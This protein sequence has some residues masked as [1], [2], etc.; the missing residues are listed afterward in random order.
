VKNGL[1]K[2]DKYY[3]EVRRGGVVVVVVV[4][5]VV[6]IARTDAFR[7]DR[8]APTDLR[9]LPTVPRATLKPRDCRA[10]AV[11]PQWSFAIARCG[12]LPRR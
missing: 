12:L 1:G 2:N 7:A 9:W 11:S 8:S 5:V 6:A 3:F 4:V 10:C